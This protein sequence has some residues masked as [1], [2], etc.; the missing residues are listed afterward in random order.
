MGSFALFV[1]RK[2]T[3][4]LGDAEDF[5]GIGKFAATFADRELTGH[6]GR[7][8]APASRHAKRRS[9][10]IVV[11]CHADMITRNGIGHKAEQFSPEQIWQET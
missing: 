2:I 9:G 6:P 4:A 5:A 10:A 7:R 3:G 11:G 8:W 1:D